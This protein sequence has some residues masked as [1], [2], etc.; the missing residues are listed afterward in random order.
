MGKLLLLILAV[1][2]ACIALKGM[3]R[4]RA[5]RGAHGRQSLVPAV[6]AVDMVPCAFCG[7]NFPS[8][9]AVAGEGRLFCDAEHL[10]QFLSRG[11]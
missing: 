1:V 7:V 9:E 4:L 6:K 8:G 11:T 3:G 2:V 10:R 5:Q